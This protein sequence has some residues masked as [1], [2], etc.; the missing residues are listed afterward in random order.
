LHRV[1][2][3]PIP[4]PSSTRADV[5]AA[6]DAIVMKA[7]E[8]DPEQRYGSAAEMARDLSE[9]VVGA[10]FHI[11]DV[12]LFL[13]EIEPLLAG[14]RGAAVDGDTSSAATKT[15]DLAAETTKRDLMHR[16][17]MSPLGR[18]FFGRWKS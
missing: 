2:E 7:L 16:L 1:L 15:K 17:R 12:A 4:L 3:M 8:R 11:D 10:R 14:P 6:L 18:L 13:R 5:P 9:F